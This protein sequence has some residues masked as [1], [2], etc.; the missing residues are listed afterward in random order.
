LGV[1][2]EKIQQEVVK[3]PKSKSGWFRKVQKK[4]FGYDR[5][6]HF[7]EEVSNAEALLKRCEDNLLFEP[8]DWKENGIRWKSQLESLA[9]AAGNLA[10]IRMHR[11]TQELF[12]PPPRPGFFKRLFG[13]GKSGSE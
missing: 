3:E 8:R 6:E 1:K 11:M 12:N 4:R 5:E 10:K 7:S 2:K 13:V 9:V